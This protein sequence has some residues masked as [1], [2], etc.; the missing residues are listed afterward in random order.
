MKID[1]SLYLITDR[2]LA[3]GKPIQDIVAKALQGGVTCVQVREK[4]CDGNEFLVISRSIQKISRAA[5]VPFL[6]NDRIDI[7]LVSDA[8]GVHIGQDDIP[9]GPA[10]TLVGSNRLVGVSAGTIEDAREAEAGG[11]DY[12][13]A[14]PVFS[15]DTKNDA[16]KP[17][18]IE[19]L[20]Q[21][22]E[23]VSIPVVGIGGI[24]RKN[25]RGVIQCGA[26]GAAVISAI[27]SAENPE[28]AAREIYDVIQEARQ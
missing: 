1:F 2:G 17:I 25:V 16:G 11:A 22:V 8:D 12:I 6:I 20:Q 28:S 9:L 18:G 15:T 13:G 23:S 26:A 5:N 24:H 27:I 21:I 10:R 7:A 3:P 4:N 19:G 14:G